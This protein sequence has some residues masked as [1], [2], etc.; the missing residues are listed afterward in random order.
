MHFENVM[1]FKTYT[2]NKAKNFNL[3]VPVNLFALSAVILLFALSLA[4][5]FGNPPI[6]LEILS[7]ILLVS[8]LTLGGTLLAY[9][10]NYLFSISKDGWRK[11]VVAILLWL[12]SLGTIPIAAKISGNDLAAMALWLAP[13]LVVIVAILCTFVLSCFRKSRS[14]IVTNL[15][16][17]LL[18]LFSIAWS[19]W[20]MK[21]TGLGSNP[22]FYNFHWIPVILFSIPF[23]FASIPYFVQVFRINSISASK[24]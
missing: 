20:Y 8:S 3:I 15:S 21:A 10:I 1:K 24:P 19:L 23:F 9:D 5:Y 7:P 14:S 12:V 16:S 13:I 4:K 18:L 22:C 17:L 11:F 2:A 6:F